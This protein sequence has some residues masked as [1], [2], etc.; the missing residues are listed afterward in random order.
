MLKFAKIFGAVCGVLVVAGGANAAATEADSSE[1]VIQTTGGAQNIVIRVKVRSKSSE[2][3]TA[4]T[5]GTAAASSKPVRRKLKSG[6]DKWIYEKPKP[7]EVKQ[8]VIIDGKNSAKNYEYDLEPIDWEDDEQELPPSPKPR[9]VGEWRTI[10]VDTNLANPFFQ[11]QQGRFTFDIDARQTNHSFKF[12]VKDAYTPSVVY[13]AGASSVN[14]EGKKFGFDNTQSQYLGRITYGITD[15]LEINGTV[16]GYDQRFV[17]Q[18]R[19]FAL[20]STLALANPPHDLTNAGS[21]LESWGL[22]VAWR[23]YDYNEV[24]FQV[25]GEYRQLQYEKASEVHLGVQGGIVNGRSTFYGRLGLYLWNNELDGYGYGFGYGATDFPENLWE[26]VLFETDNKHPIYVEGT[27]GIFTAL[28]DSVSLDVNT[29]LADLSWRSVW[30]IGSQLA[31]QPV[32]AF[33]FMLYGSYNLYDSSAGVST[34]PDDNQLVLWSNMSP[35]YGSDRVGFR[36]VSGI[37]VS[38]PREFTFGAGIKVLF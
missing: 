29:S 3:G 21:G 31:F 16:A 4:T 34:S 38:A 23:V 32:D 1:Q 7:V 17:Y 24:L 26:K 27:A 8:D 12:K 35:Q 20:D 36:P 5:A 10:S 6:P 25:R 22:G 14:L 18:N 15:A 13:P 28:N 2:S 19:S 11:P 30:S 33:M 9:A 37:N